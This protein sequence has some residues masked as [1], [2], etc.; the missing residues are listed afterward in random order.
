VA[1]ADRAPGALLWLNPYVGDLD[2]IC[3]TAP[4]GYDR[5]ACD[6]VASVTGTPFFSAP[7][8]DECPD[9][10]CRNVFVEGDDAVAADVD[11]DVVA[12]PDAVARDVVLKA[13][14]FAVVGAAAMEPPVPD[15]AR[16]DQQRQLTTFG[17]PRDTFWPQSALAF[18]VLGG[19]LKLVSAQLVSPTR[20]FRLLRWSPVPEAAW[21]TG[22]TRMP[23]DAGPVGTPTSPDDPP[24]DPPATREVTR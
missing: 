8:R 23:S 18:V 16:A 20:R 6:Y 3:T 9:G 13:P 11:P 12:R 4:G 24:T 2:L 15:P 14:G 21:G 17:F 22:D 7:R 1:R 19:V 10:D 5:D